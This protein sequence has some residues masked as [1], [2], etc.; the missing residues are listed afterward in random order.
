MPLKIY[1]CPVTGIVGHRSPIP[2]SFPAEG[3]EGTHRPLVGG[4]TPEQEQGRRR[5][6]SR[7]GAFPTLP[8]V[9]RQ[10]TPKYV[11][12]YPFWEEN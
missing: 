4:L 12:P 11:S 8:L 5:Q 2:G 10:Q 9:G 7:A 1:S 3:G 6:C